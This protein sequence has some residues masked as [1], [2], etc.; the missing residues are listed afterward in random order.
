[1]KTLCN[2]LRRVL[3]KLEGK[4]SG[5]L[6]PT[7]IEFQ[8]AMALSKIADLQRN[9]CLTSSDIG[10]MAARIAEKALEY[11]LHGRTEELTKPYRPDPAEEQAI[12]DAFNAGGKQ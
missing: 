11:Q 10:F 1:M 2:C 3:E 9:M 4:V 8:L 7:V 12:Q 6:P 5:P